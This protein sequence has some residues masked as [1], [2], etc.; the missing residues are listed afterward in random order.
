M[1]DLKNL[2]SSP[3]IVFPTSSGTIEEDSRESFDSRDITDSKDR[4]DS[5]D[6]QGS[7]YVQCPKKLPSQFY[8]SSRKTN[9]PQPETSPLCRYASQQVVG[10]ECQKQFDAENF[11]KTG[12]IDILSYTLIEKNVQLDNQA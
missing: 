2:R 11:E 6:F 8:I 4:D 7:A 3:F 9:Q 1:R 10:I 12:E 5:L